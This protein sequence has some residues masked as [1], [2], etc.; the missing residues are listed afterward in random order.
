[1]TP[2][3]RFHEA[4]NRLAA[5]EERFRREEFLAPVVRGGGV[6]VRIAGVVCQFALRPRDFEGWGVFRASSAGEATLVRSAR[7][8]ERQCYLEL[9]PVVRLVLCGQEG[10]TWSGLPAHQADG[11]FRLRRLV[12][13]HLVEETRTF[14]VVEAR[15]D[16]T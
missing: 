5:A 4:L 14:E 15:F 12:P 2:S 3:K 6:R 1:M 11:R 7:L 9:F 8:P 13:V 16:G 10:R